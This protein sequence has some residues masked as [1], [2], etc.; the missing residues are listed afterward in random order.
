MNTIERD[1]RLRRGI[2]RALYVAMQNSPSGEL[3]GLS[4][5]D[6]AELGLPFDQKFTDDVHAMGL[7]RHMVLKGYATERSA[8]RRKGELFGLRHLVFRI[9]SQGAELHMENREPDPDV[10]DDRIDE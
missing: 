8:G 1:K 7:M 5:K 10:D 2:L 3:S 6:E 9:T 4:L